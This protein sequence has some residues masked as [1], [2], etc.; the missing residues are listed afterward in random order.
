MINAY[1]LGFAGLLL[2]MGTI[3][4]RYGRKRLM[5]AGLPAFAV[6]SWWRLGPKAPTR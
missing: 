4:D 6:A 3:G 1:V 5:L 2:P